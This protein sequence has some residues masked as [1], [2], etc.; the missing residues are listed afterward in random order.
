[1]RDEEPL[2][3]GCLVRGHRLADV[4][5]PARLAVERAPLER[6]LAQEEVGL[7]GEPEELVGRGR[8]ARVREGRLGARDSE[9]VR[10]DER[11]VNLPKT[12]DGA[13]FMQYATY[14]DARGDIPLNWDYQGI[15][16]LRA[17][18]VGTPAII[19]GKYTS[20]SITVN[21]A[22]S[23]YQPAGALLYMNVNG[24]STRVAPV[25][26]SGKGTA[27]TSVT[28][29]IKFD[30]NHPL[31]I[32]HGVSTPLD[33][34]FDLSAA[35]I[36]D[37]TTSP[38]QVTVRPFI[39]ASTVPNYTRPLRAR[40]VYVSTDTGGKNFTMNARS[41][42]DTQGSPVGAIGI[43]T[44]DST[45]YNINGTL[46][47]GAAGLDAINK[48]QIN[49]IVEA[50]GSFGDLNNI[51]PNF[52]ATQ[53]YAGVAVENVLTDRITGTVSSRNGT[54]LHIKGAEV[55]ALPIFHHGGIS[56]ARRI[57]CSRR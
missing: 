4:E 50:Y 41:F 53:V 42:F 5:V 48:L 32:K 52:V 49:T 18:V 10:L 30:P 11:F 12:L 29:T 13:A 3:P 22:A 2:G 57:A 47:Q 19:E 46:Y 17:N 40:G 28:Y 54:T 27:A 8:V 34:N 1:M 26:T 55:E 35:S 51:K 16:W 7:A 21:Y 25:D 45:V 43:Q 37:T 39:S 23:T 9:P 33:F 44:N 6:R 31:V 14:R 56:R 15:Q 20:V 36:V 38:Y 24:T